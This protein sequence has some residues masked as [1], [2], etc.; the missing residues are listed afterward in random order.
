MSRFGGARLRHSTTARFVFLYLALSLVGALPILFFIYHQTD[1]V[2]VRGHQ[3]TVEDRTAILIGGYRAGGTAELAREVAERSAG[4]LAHGVLLL[5]DRS[6]RKLAGNVGAWPPSLGNRTTW[7]EMLLYREGHVRPERFGLSTT[8][9]PSGERLL[10]GVVVDDRAP[11]REALLISMLGALILA[12]PIGLLGSFVLVRFMNSRVN[13]IADVAGGIAAG[14]LG[15]RVETEGTN[16]PFD[17]LAMSLNAMLARIEDLVDQL[18]LVTDALAHDLRSPLMRMRAGLEKAVTECE[19]STALQALESIAREIDGMMRLTSS[20]LEISRT[21]AGIGRENFSQFDL[22]TLLRDLCE[23]YDPLAEE[24]GI[25]INVHDPGEKLDYLGN[26][27]LLGQA[28]SNLIDN[29]LKYANGGGI[30]LGADEEAGEVRLWVADRGPGIPIDRR[31]A[32][33]EKYHRLEQARTSEGS[34]LGLAMVRAV[35]RLHGGDLTLEDNEPGLR[36]VI[37]LSRRDRPGREAE[38]ASASSA[39]T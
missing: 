28:V 25:P 29:A 9:L 32:A 23:M 18:R 26:R 27:E 8:Q 37:R 16:D 39:G 35:A 36:A 12:I 22:A 30:Q 11:V 4:P 24:R 13:E 17:R 6:G 21:E 15:R 20:T 3:S 10:V 31:D 38:L 34:G 2:V 14:D 19:D 33:I 1:R 7:R 5:T